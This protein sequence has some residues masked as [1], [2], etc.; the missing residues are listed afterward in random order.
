MTHISQEIWRAVVLQPDTDYASGG[1]FPFKSVRYET[2]IFF[3]YC[4]GFLLPFISVEKRGQKKRKRNAPRKHPSNGFPC[5]ALMNVV[6]FRSPGTNFATVS[7]MGGVHDFTLHS[8]PHTSSSSIQ[9]NFR[10]RRCIVWSIPPTSEIGS[11]KYD[12]FTAPLPYLNCFHL[13]NQYV[14]VSVLQNFKKLFSSLM[15]KGSLWYVWW[16]VN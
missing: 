12:I 3:F 15:K 2:F 8:K 1:A 9:E 6:R 11:S 16:V 14:H 10:Q 4:C 5:K 7:K 13:P